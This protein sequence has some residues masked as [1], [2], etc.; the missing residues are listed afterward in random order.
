MTCSA[1]IKK[2]GSKV[3][4]ARND[5][6][7]AWEIVGGIESFSH[8][9]EA[10]TEDAT[11]S[12]TIGDILENAATGFKSS[13]IDITGKSSTKTG[14]E[15][16]TG[17]NIVGTLR[18]SDLFYAPGSCGKFQIRDVATGGLIEGT[19]IISAYNVDDPKS[20][21]ETFTA[22]LTHQSGFTRTGAI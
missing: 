5:A 8:S 14:V 4:L 21:L 15:P 2:G 19:Y 12:S 3:L 1:D 13:G 18:L 20:G 22:T 9:G 6:D 10:A 7:N 16:V 17:L 11:S